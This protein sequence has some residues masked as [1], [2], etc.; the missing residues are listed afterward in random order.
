MKRS[1]VMS[2]ILLLFL[3]SILAVEGM[4]VFNGPRRASSR[5]EKTV[6]RDG[7]SGGIAQVSSC[8]FS[9]QH[10]NTTLYSVFQYDK[11]F[12]ILYCKPPGSGD[13]CQV[14]FGL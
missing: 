3:S 10:N 11:I 12:S 2:Y 7:N 9:Q 1:V 6:Y 14:I 5:L 8:S 4:V 13:V